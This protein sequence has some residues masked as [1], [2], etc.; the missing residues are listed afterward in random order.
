MTVILVGYNGLD[1]TGGQGDRSLRYSPHVHI[2]INKYHA[3]LTFLLL[4]N[5]LLCLRFRS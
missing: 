1:P 2:A 3:E 4:K 5:L